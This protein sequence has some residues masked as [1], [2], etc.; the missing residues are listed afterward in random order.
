MQFGLKDYYTFISPVFYKHFVVHCCTG[1]FPGNDFSFSTFVVR[2]LYL[3]W[4]FGSA[5]KPYLSPL[6]CIKGFNYSMLLYCVQSAETELLSR[7]AFSESVVFKNHMII[8]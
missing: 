4:L 2:H 7:V 8:W 6:H 5:G 1:R 3:Y